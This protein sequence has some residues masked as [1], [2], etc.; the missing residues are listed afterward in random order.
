MINRAIEIVKENPWKVTIGTLV[1]VVAT[2]GGTYFNDTRYVKK[3]EY[4]ASMTN[5]LNEVNRLSL[6][7]KSLGK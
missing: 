6:E 2:V 1:T 7:Q 5:I 3:S 4:E